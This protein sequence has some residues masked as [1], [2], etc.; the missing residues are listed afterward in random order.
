MKALDCVDCERSSGSEPRAC[1]VFEV[2]GTL[3]SMTYLKRRKHREGNSRRMKRCYD[4]DNF[5][6]VSI[7]VYTIFLI[8]QLC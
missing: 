2:V 1:L 4:Y 7:I 5:M 8:L 3:R 6:C